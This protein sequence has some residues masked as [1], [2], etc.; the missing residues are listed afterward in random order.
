MSDTAIT[1]GALLLFGAAQ[2]HMAKMMSLIVGL[3]LLA[4][5]VI[6]VIDGDDVLGLN[7]VPER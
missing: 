7:S 2:H 6:A 5:A 4:C 3:A 1:A